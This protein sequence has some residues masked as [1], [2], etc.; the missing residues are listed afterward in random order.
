[1]ATKT[2]ANQ[3]TRAAGEKLVA[4]NRQARHDYFIEET[5]EAGLA[6]TGTEIKSIRAGRLNLRE[7][8]ARVENGEAW[9]VGMHVSPY[10]QAG[11]AFQHDPLRPRKLLLHRR[12][13]AYLRAQ[14][15]QK[16]LTLVPLRLYLKRGR[17]KVELGLAKGRK[18]YDK[19]DSLAAREA[20]RD[21]ERALRG[22]D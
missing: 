8:Y 2:S 1:M 17:A 10:D 11:G 22:R 13:I 6:L 12:E 9:L 20:R 18:L 14:L 5:F 21:V 19:R 3:D 16:G 15:G 4:T 7:A